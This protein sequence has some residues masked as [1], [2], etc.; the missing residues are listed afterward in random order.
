MP[1]HETIFSD[2]VEPMLPPGT[3]AQL[4]NFDHRWLWIVDDE[5][6]PD[7]QKNGQM[8]AFRRWSNV[9]LNIDIPDLLAGEDL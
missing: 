5:N 7:D 8:Q 2:F 1:D 6:K 4:G 3:A 9:N